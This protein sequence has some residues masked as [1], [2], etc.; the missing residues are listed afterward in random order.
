MVKRVYFKIRVLLFRLLST[1]VPS[2]D[3]SRKIGPV[4]MTGRGKINLGTVDFGVEEGI[5]FYS[6]YTL[7]DSR[8]ENDE[9]RIGNQVKINNGFSAITSN[10]SI[11]IGNNVLIG[12]SVSI[13]ASDF[14]AINPKDRDGST[15]KINSEN[16]IIG[17]EVFIGAN[18]TLLKGVVVPNGSVIPAGM[19][20][21]KGYF[22]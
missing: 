12:N 15:E 19:T 18:V 21:R 20:I 13:F 10:S 14:H 7:L 9:I 11:T 4:L 8:R 6:S 5:G 16:V 17:D 1:N 3:F 22:D 2:K